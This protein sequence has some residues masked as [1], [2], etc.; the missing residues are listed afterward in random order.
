MIEYLDK[1]EAY[2]IWD[3]VECKWVKVGSG[4]C[5]WPKV[6]SAKNAL[7]YEPP[8]REICPDLWE[9]RN[10]YWRNKSFD[11]QSRFIIKSICK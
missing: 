9:N 8:K 3:T 2:G 6:G 1:I 11:S 5:V 10:G 4:K 7:L